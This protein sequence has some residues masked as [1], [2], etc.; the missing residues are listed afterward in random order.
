MVILV[1]LALEGDFLIT[2]DTDSIRERSG[3]RFI[4]CSPPGQP[5]IIQ[6]RP[7][8]PTCHRRIAVAFRF[9]IQTVFD[10]IL[11]HH[12]VHNVAFFPGIQFQ[13]ILTG[14]PKFRIGCVLTIIHPNTFRDLTIFRKLAQVHMIAF[15][16]QDRVNGIVAFLNGFRICHIGVIRNVEFYTNLWL[17]LHDGSG[18]AI[19]SGVEAAINQAPGVSQIQLTA[20]E[21]FLL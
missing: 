11:F 16:V 2:D 14:L 3:V 15:P 21:V 8:A 10:A 7:D 17:S 19:G 13:I 12:A 4:V 9:V 1:S 6:I 5:F 20:C 18:E